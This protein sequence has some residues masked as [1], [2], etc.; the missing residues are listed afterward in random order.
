[1]IPKAWW[2]EQRRGQCKPYSCVHQAKVWGEAL[3]KQNS[4]QVCEP[5]AEISN[6]ITNENTLGVCYCKCK[7]LCRKVFAKSGL[8]V[9]R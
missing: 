7:T 5:K 1:M 2:K 6:A 9:Q 3:S 8:S 4:W